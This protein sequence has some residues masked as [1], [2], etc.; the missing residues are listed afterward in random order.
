MANFP[1]A[2]ITDEFTQDFERI[3]RTAVDMGIPAL[4]LRTVWDKNIVDMN[5][6]EIR[7]V[8]QLANEFKLKIVSIASPV[9]KCTLPDGGDIDH[10]FEQDA[11]H[12][13]HTYEDQPRIL[14][15]ALEVANIFGAPIVRVFSFWRTVEPAKITSRIVEALKEA[16][17]QGAAAGVK[18]GLENEHACNIATASESATVL[19][20]VDNP[21][22]GLVWDPANC[23][24]AGER[25]YPDGYNLLPANR[26]LHVHAKDGVL[27]PGSDRMN[28][29]DLGA[30]D[31]DWTGQLAAMVRDGYSGAVSLETHWGGPGGDKFKGSSICAKSLQRLVSEA[32]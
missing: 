17:E 28:W 32:A 19:N 29:G 12:S 20:A 23:Y 25:P 8:D 5:D 11:F 7:Q 24:I 2:I 15:R 14:A 16:A 27:P 1:V 21:N 13:A 31:V 22:L 9:F 4:E 10:R 3:C 18:I 26:I 30:G 6:E